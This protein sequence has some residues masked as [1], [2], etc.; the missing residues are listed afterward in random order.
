MTVNSLPSVEPTSLWKP[1]RSLNQ[2]VE[3]IVKAIFA[4]F[5]LLSIVTTIGIVATLIFET[6]EFLKEV[7]L[8]GIS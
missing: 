8:W 7:P 3:F 4:S 2:R 1:N 6:F 5:A